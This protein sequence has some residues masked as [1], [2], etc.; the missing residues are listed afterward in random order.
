MGDEEHEFGAHEPEG[1]PRGDGGV[2]GGGVPTA[3]AGVSQGTA[4]EEPRCGCGGGDGHEEDEEE[5]GPVVNRATASGGRRSRG[6]RG[7]RHRRADAAGPRRD[8]GLRSNQTW[9]CIW[10][11]KLGASFL[12]PCFSLFFLLF[13]LSQ[14]KLYQ[15][16]KKTS[17][18]RDSNHCAPTKLYLRFQHR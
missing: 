16:S 7:L 10:R 5:P 13:L 11:A 1:T 8:C 17:S 15:L 18:L 3:V 6:R 4:E 9:E 14:S 2:E 12:R